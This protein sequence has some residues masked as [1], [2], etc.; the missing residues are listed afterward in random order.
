MEKRMLV[1]MMIVI[2][3]SLNVFAEMVEGNNEEHVCTSECKHDEVKKEGS[4]DKNAMKDHKCDEKCEVA[5]KHVCTAE[6]KED[7][8][9]CEQANLKEQCSTSAA[10]QGCEMGKDANKQGCGIMKSEQK[11]EGKGC[12]QQ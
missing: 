11:T 4:V 5:G 7:G 2:V 10:K 3:F 1:M 9:K 12:S 8:K 6:C